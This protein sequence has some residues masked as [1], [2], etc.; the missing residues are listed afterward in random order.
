MCEIIGFHAGDSSLAPGGSIS[1]V[2]API[3]ARHRFSHNINLKACELSRNIWF[4]Y[5]SAKVC[6]SL[7][8]QKQLYYYGFNFWRAHW[9]REMITD[10]CLCTTKHVKRISIILFCHQ[11]L[12]GRNIMTIKISKTFYEQ[13][14]YS[15]NCIHKIWLSFELPILLCEQ[16]LNIRAYTWSIYLDNI[17]RFDVLY[18]RKCRNYFTLLN[19]ILKKYE[20]K[21]NSK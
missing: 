10:V 2:Y 5:T 7:Q 6:T 16:K 20:S 11:G 19:F 15:Q 3:I 8:S 18:T 1:N 12:L 17:K 13:P 4:F 14:L 21:N 9:I